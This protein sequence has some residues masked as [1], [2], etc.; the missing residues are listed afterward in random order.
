MGP[1]L[2]A[3]T[4]LIIQDVQ[5]EIPCFIPSVPSSSLAFSRHECW[6]CDRCEVKQPMQPRFIFEEIND[7]KIAIMT[8]L[9]F[10]NKYVKL[11]L[12]LSAI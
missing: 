6:V 11:V 3:N 9:A 2:H 12:S 1:P 5:S 7:S 8:Y 10:S 4:M